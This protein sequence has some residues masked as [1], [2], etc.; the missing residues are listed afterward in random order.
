MQHVNHSGLFHAQKPQNK[1]NSFFCDSNV[2][3]NSALCGQRA[4]GFMKYGGVW[5]VEMINQI[6]KIS[7]SSQNPPRFHLWC[8]IF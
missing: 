3:Q 2:I 7:F 6:T 4:N 5:E 1:E 8:N